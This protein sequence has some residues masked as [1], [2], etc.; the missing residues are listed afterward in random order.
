MFWTQFRH[1]F[2][3]YYYRIFY[4]HVGHI[5]SYRLTFIVYIDFLLALTLYSTT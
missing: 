1:G 5:V 3:F 2:Q 4:Q